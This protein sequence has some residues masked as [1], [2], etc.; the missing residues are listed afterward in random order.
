MPITEILK[1]LRSSQKTRS[2]Q[3]AIE[4]FHSCVPCNSSIEDV[5]THFNHLMDNIEAT[6]NIRADRSH[7]IT[8][9]D[10][11][12]YTIDDINAKINREEC[13]IEY[14]LD[15]YQKCC[16]NG[17]LPEIEKFKC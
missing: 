8:M 6:R 3:D 12:T 13:W 15:R 16:K 14:H 17:K 10:G 5:T 9:K 2:G 1:K 7:S 4:L 11:I